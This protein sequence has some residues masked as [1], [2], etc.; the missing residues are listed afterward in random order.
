MLNKIAR[1]IVNDSLD[2]FFKRVLTVHYDQRRQT[3]LES[4]DRAI[5]AIDYILR[6]CIKESVTYPPESA[7]QWNDFFSRLESGD[8][9]VFKQVLLIYLKLDANNYLTQKETSTRIRTKDRTELA[10]LEAA[11]NGLIPLPIAFDFPN[12]VIH[13]GEGLWAVDNEKTSLIVSSLSCPTIQLANYFEFPQD[14]SNIIVDSHIFSHNPRMALFMSKI[15]RY[16]KWD[17][18]Y[19]AIYAFLLISSGQ[20]I[21]ALKYERIF[22][23]RDNY[24]DI[25]QRF[26]ELCS[27]W[28]AIKSLNCLNLTVE[29]EEILNR[30]LVS[31]SRP[32]TPSGSQS[33][34][35]V[36]S[37]PKPRSRSIQ[38]VQ[39]TPSFND[40]PARNTRSARK[41]KAV[42]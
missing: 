15:H 23:D 10:S 14:L 5:P 39:R 25:L 4:N 9:K 1:S 31:E 35:A 22:S 27:R 18:N 29:E 16:E 6:T 17:E 3:L 11:L 33:K 20:L 36:S 19:D 21:E 37:R 40:S 34:G 38:V 42:K 7:S 8:N 2:W 28:Q 13:L 32:V 12:S 26:F 24:L 41:K 30:H